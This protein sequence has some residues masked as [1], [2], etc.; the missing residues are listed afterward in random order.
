MNKWYVWSGELAVEIIA[1]CPFKACIT[2]LANHGG[3]KTLDSRYF[4]VDLPGFR[5]SPDDLTKDGV[6]Y[7]VEDV[8]KAA[9]HVFEDG[10]E[11]EGC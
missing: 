7:D 8:V 6:V 4:T 11:E 1:P 2:A 9:G 3:G 5:T 10:L